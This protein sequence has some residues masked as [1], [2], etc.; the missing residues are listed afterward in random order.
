L[1]FGCLSW[2]GKTWRSEDMGQAELVPPLGGELG[3]RQRARSEELVAE[4]VVK[5]LDVAVIPRGDGI[6]VE[7]VYLR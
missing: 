3:R 2:A 5:A 7:G 4:I 1:G 6:D